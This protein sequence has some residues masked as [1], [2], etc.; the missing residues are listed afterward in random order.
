VLVTTVIG[1]LIGL[2]AS[3]YSLFSGQDFS[4]V[5][6]S[7]Q[8]AL[9]VLVQQASSYSG[10]VLVLLIAVKVLTYGLSLSAFRGGPVFPALFIG[11]A[12]VMAL[13]GLPGMSHAPAIGI[14]IGAMCSAMLRTWL[15]STLLATLLLGG[16]GLTE[17]P[18]VVVAVAVAFVVTMVL[19]TAGPVQAAPERQ[20]SMEGERGNPIT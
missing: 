20:P 1:L 16:A 10:G 19:P 7:G 15:T 13:A 14:A 17:T 3:G 6:F 5:L 8:T 4:Q 11:A 9:P 12:L 2:C 18:V